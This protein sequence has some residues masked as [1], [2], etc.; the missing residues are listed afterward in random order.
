M[1]SVL[2]TE[3][4]FSILLSLT[5]RRLCHSH[6]SEILGTLAC[7]CSHQLYT[8]TQDVS[9][10]PQQLAPVTSPRSDSQHSIG[11]QDFNLLISVCLLD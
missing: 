4:D 7:L 8:V 9:H 3:E 2:K 6:G 11:D 10:S 5:Q 1:T